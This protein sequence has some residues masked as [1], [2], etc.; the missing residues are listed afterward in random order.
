MLMRSHDGRVDHRVL[1]VGI[2]RQGFEK[3]LPNAARGPAREALVRVAPAA[4][5]LRQIAPRR[6][7]PEFP[8]HRIDEKTI[9][10]IAVATDRAR[11]AGQQILD[12]G[13]LI[14]SQS[15]AF[16]RKPPSRRLPMNHALADLRILRFL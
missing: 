2:V 14:V 3:I 12:P 1:V 16:H 13:E 8:D 4:E 7:H 15:M 5:M 9:A 6:P 10:P 11:T